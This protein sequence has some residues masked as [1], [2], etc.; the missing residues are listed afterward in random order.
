MT[1][2][3]KLVSL[4]VFV[5][6]SFVALFIV[7]EYTISKMQTLSKTSHNFDSVTID[8]F[9]LRKNE[10]DFLARKDLKYLKIFNENFA[11]FKENLKSLES[12]LHDLGS[13]SK[14]VKD[15]LHIVE[16]YKIAFMNLV[17]EQKHIGLTPEDS[18]Y[19]KL[20][21]AVQLVQKEAKR[22]ND[23]ELLAGVYELRKQEKDF[24]LRKDTKYI[25]N[26]NK[27]IFYLINNNS[28]VKLNK[29]L[30]TYH[31]D[32]LA[33]VKAEKNKGLSANKGL[34][35]KMRKI[36]Q[37]TEE[38]LKKVRKHIEHKMLTEASSIETFSMVFII[39]VTILVMFILFSIGRSIT[40][41]LKEFE[42]G[43]VNFFKYLNNEVDDVKLLNDKNN[44]E[45]GLMSKLINKNI[46]NT[47]KLIEED[48]ALIKD[49]TSVANK[50]KLGYLDNVIQANTSNES[51][52][53]LKNVINEMLQNLNKNIHNILEVLGAYSSN[54]YLPRVNVD[55]VEGE[56]L[57][58]CNNTNVV[59]NTIS[60][61][62]ED[63]KNNGVNLEKSAE[64]LLANVDNLNKGSNETAASLEETAAALEE[65]TSTIINN[66]SSIENM[67]NLSNK[68]IESAKQGEKLA[69]DTAVSMDVLNEQVVSI[70]ESIGIIDQI[71][72]QTNILS[73]NAAVEAATAGEAGKGFAVVAQEV[74]NLA[75]R[76]SDAAK[77]I[78]ELVEN[79]TLKASHS[80]DI[81]NNMINGYT[82][83][84]THIQETINN[85]KDVAIASKEQREGIE[86]INDTVSRLDQ[87]TQNNAS[88]ANETQEIARTTNEIATKMVEEVDK[89][90]F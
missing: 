58:L 27:N 86:Q 81:A 52:N 6:I 37:Q 28:N 43:L 89:N 45:I 88:I 25:K 83:L 44:D 56:I 40:S 29:Y 54:N 1:I 63:S 8:I 74:R 7:E 61:L 26:F 3:T 67:T 41:S 80:K 48:K 64:S 39:L 15:V 46:K 11:E 49:A 16:A 68:V 77:E 62:L 5:F 30:K 55:N 71:A 75:S 34:L 50:I 53:N 51:L 4:S 78:K 10:K 79:A 90:K 70:N 12:H 72:F 9:K 87:Q 57:E 21:R 24:M 42:V 73:L 31:K 2:K 84:N 32:F 66:T 76:S 85:I 19:G 69:Q 82:Q 22:I 20:R 59:G 60:N 23:F 14:D 17:D 38:T 36:I 65:I 35:G 33:L 18:L 13:T 47:Q